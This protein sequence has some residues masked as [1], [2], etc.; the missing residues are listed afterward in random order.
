[1]AKT[2]VHPNLACFIQIIKSEFQYY[3]QHCN[4]ISQNFEVIYKDKTK[5]HNPDLIEFE[6][7][8]KRNKIKKLIIC[9]FG[10]FKLCV[11]LTFR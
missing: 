7:Y 5:K 3:Q 11:F 10:H 2:N 9:Q 6:K 8:I 4:P 1:M